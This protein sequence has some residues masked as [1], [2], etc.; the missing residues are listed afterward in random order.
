MQ[1]AGAIDIG[2][3]N[4]RVALINTRG[5][6][7]R[8]EQFLTPV[9]GVPEDIATKSAAVLMNLVWE[10]DCILS[11]VGVA[12]AGPVNIASG[13]LENPPNIPFDIVP[14]TSP[15]RINTGFEPLLLNDCRAAV[16]GEVMAGGGKGFNT[17]VYVTISTGI[18]GGVFTSGKLL[19]GRGGNAAEIGHFFVDSTYN[20]CCTCKNKGHWEGYAS[21]RS[22]PNFF[23]EWIKIHQP[24]Y[25]GQVYTAPDILSAAESGDITVK[26]F[27]K[28]LA[29][30]NSRGLSSVI[31]AYDPDCIILDG[32]VLRS[33]TWLLDEMIEKIDRY[34]MLPLIRLTSLDGNAPL[35]GAAMGVFYPEIL[36]N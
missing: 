25:C 20:I 22:I 4:T 30:I 8:R 27:C 31:V 16:I 28:D 6:I 36:M 17:V 3:T 5:R 35:I 19:V 11:G 13:T 18:G 21:G 1:F 24:D 23:G 7:I 14:V 34:L 29:L 26:R 9:T 32:A 15:I 10:E 33:H 2:G 12:A